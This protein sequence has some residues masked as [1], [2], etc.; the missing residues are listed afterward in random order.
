MKTNYDLQN[1]IS[2]EEK[3]L[4]NQMYKSYQSQYHTGIM[5][6]TFGGWQWETEDGTC[7]RTDSS[8]EGLWLQSQNG[9]WQ[10]ISGTMQF[11]LPENRTKTIRK[12]NYIGKAPR[13]L[14]A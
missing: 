1:W 9:D 11:S 12:L 5:V 10:Q 14:I 3:E 13:K 8:G 7:Y 2:P 6:H 4:C